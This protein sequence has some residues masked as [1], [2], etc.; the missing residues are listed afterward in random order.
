MIRRGRQHDSD[1]I[2]KIFNDYIAG[3]G[4]TDTD[5]LVTSADRRTWLAQ[6]EESYPVYV[7][8]EGNHVVGWSSVSPLSARHADPRVAEI[9]VYV[10]PQYQNQGIGERLVVHALE[11]IDISQLRV[12]VAI[13]FAR[14]DRSQRLFARV[15]FE[16]VMYL[17]E[18]ALLRE[19]WEDVLWF[20]KPVAKR[21]RRELP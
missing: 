10:A 17:R 7:W 16:Q 15:G 3:G 11:H 9:G 2:A 14:N 1:D 12:V 13:V 4:L 19:K 20:A 5:E 18:A 8:D 21:T 6:H